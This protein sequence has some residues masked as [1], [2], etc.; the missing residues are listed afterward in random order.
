MKLARKMVSGLL[1]GIIVVLLVSAW[2]R[3]ERERELFDTDTQ[4]D[5]LLVGR[6]IATGLLRTWRGEGEAAGLDFVRS[7]SSE[8]HHV[9]VRWVW[10]EGT[11]EADSAPRVP[12]AVLGPLAAGKELSYRS[13]ELGYQFTY[14]PLA[15]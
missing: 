1:C 5:D 9:E 2:L 4:R 12:L 7:F 13:A 3:V 10:L 11:P 8:K 15:A 6:A 14:L